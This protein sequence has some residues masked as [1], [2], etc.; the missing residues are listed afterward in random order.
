MNLAKLLADVGARDPE[1]TAVRFE[2]R[3]VTYGRFWEAVRLHAGALADLGVRPGD[4]VA[5]QLSKRLDF[6]YLHLGVL[7]LGAITLPLN[8]DYKP[9]EVEYFLRDSGSALFVSDPERLLRA[10]AVLRD[11]PGTKPVCVDPEGPSWAQ[12]LPAALGRVPGSFRPEYPAGDDDVAVIC[13]TSGTT[14]RSKGAMITHRNLVANLLDLHEIWRWSESDVLLHVL[15]LF[16]VHGLMVAAQGALHAG[17]TLV[18]HERFDPAR[19]WDAIEADR[20]T[21]LMA[22]PTIYQRL[23]AEWDRRPRKPDLSTMRVFLSGSAPLSENLFRRFEAATGHRILERYGMTEAGMIASNPYEPERRIPGSV[24]YP[25]PSVAIRVCDDQGR[26]VPPGQIGEVW[27][28]GPNVFKGYWRMPEK[29]RE[30]LVDGW[31]RSGDLGYQDP[32]D[33]GRLYLKGRAKELIITGGY[34][35][36]PKE[37]EL[38]LE[39]HPAVRECAVVGVPDEEFGERVTAVV[40]PKP[41]VPPPAP[42]ELIALCKAKLA[43]YKCPKRVFLAEELPRNAMGKVQKN[44]LV[45]RYGDSGSQT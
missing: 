19:A 13:Y 3:P 30:A 44:R 2:G 45:E 20:C 14:G 32:G 36:Y 42:E 11:L 28:Q 6:L 9:E 26:D 34:N 39:T 24:G 31:L 29:T 5:L 7:S 23:M 10:E 4:R 15:P 8:A 22:V 12:P 35:V 33:G 37:V 1:K 21:V 40:V 38:V 41:D 25:L 16:H 17:A 18:M 43:G 27:V